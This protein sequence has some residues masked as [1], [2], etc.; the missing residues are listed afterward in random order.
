[1]HNLKHH[2]CLKNIKELSLICQGNLYDYNDCSIS[3]DGV[4]LERVNQ[5]KFLGVI[6]DD[7][8][9]WKKLSELLHF[10]VVIPI[11]NQCF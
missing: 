4:I 10:L 6:L 3:I 11:L 2:L 8:L 5:T 7:N 1:M 9:L